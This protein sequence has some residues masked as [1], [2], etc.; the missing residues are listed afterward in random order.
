MSLLEQKL[1]RVYPFKLKASPRRNRDNN[2]QGGV[3]ER[4]SGC[5][6]Y[7]PGKEEI[8]QWLQSC[9]V[10]EGLTL[11]CLANHEEPSR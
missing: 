7:C 1:R 8:L 3:Q 2:V 5:Y 4:R 6:Q 9:K 11:L 10:D